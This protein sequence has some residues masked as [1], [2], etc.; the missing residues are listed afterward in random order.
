MKIIICTLMLIWSGVAFSA[1]PETGWWWNPEEPGRGFNI[2]RQGDLVFIAAF[3]YENDGEPIWYT[4]IGSINESGFL[5][6]E[7]TRFD[8]G[9]CPSCEFSA[10]IP[11]KAFDVQFSF[12]SGRSGTVIIDGNI[13]PIERFNFG[14]SSD[15]DSLRGEWYFLIE[16]GGITSQVFEHIFFDDPQKTLN[17]RYANSER[18]VFASEFNIQQ[19]THMVVGGKTDEFQEIY[20]LRNVGTN[21]WEGV[22]SSGI[23]SIEEPLLLKALRSSNQVTAIRVN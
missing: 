5:S 1:I 18:Q 13:I 23:D 12:N 7:L 19:F 22:Y 17:G 6:S 3:I 4:S 9:Q 8:D 14:Y 21:K 10:P 16:R 20:L 11:A 15:L 2:E